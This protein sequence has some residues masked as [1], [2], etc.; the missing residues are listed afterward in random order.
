MRKPNLPRKRPRRSLKQIL[1]SPRIA[2]SRFSRSAAFTPK[3]TSNESGAFCRPRGSL[4]HFLSI[5]TNLYRRE[6]GGSKLEYDSEN[7]IFRFKWWGK[8]GHTYFIQH[9]E[10]LVTWNWLPL[11]EPG[12]NSIKEWAFTSTGNKFFVRLRYTDLVTADAADGDFDGDGVPY[13]AEVNQG[14]DPFVKLDSDNDGMPDDWEKFFLS[15]LTFTATQDSDG[16][17]SSNLQEYQGATAPND[18]ASK[19]DEPSIRYALLDLSQVGMDDVMPKAINNQ[20]VLCGNKNN[21]VNTSPVRWQNGQLTQLSSF[22][23][24]ARDIND[25]GTVI[26]WED[27]AGAERRLMCWPGGAL[28]IPS[29]WA[30]AYGVRANPYEL[31]SINIS[32]EITGSLLVAPLDAEGNPINTSTVSS[33]ATYWKDDLVQPMGYP[34]QEDL[35]S[36][37]GA[38]LEIW[39]IALKVNDSGQKLVHN[40]QTQFADASYTNGVVH[41]DEWSLDGTKLDYKGRNGAS[42][43]NDRGEVLG[44]RGSGWFLRKA[45]GTVDALRGGEA[46]ALNDAQRRIVDT[47]GNFLRMEPS[48]QAVGKMGGAGAIWEK[49]QKTNKF[50]QVWDLN[51]RLSPA[52]QDKWN[53]TEAI[54]INDAGV[55][56][57]Q[58]RNSQSSAD[59]PVLLLPV[60]MITI[61]SFIPHNYV[62]NPIPFSGSIF[63]GDNRNSGSPARATWNAKGSHRTHTEFNIVA[64]QIADS[65]GLLDN[66]YANDSDGVKNDEYFVNIGTTREYDKATSLNSSGNISAAAKADTSLNDGNLKIAETT[67]PKSDV[68]IE[69]TEFLSSKKIAVTCRCEAPNPLVSLSFFGPISYTFVITIDK[70]NPVAPKYSLTGKCK[71]FPAYE[72]YIG[73]S[74]IYQYD[75]LVDGRTPSW[76]LLPPISIPDQIDKP[77]P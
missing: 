44:Q 26:G 48:T 50:Y 75:P 55:I 43:L 20:G 18:S 71:S 3:R 63:E 65:N 67:A 42:D 40:D 77:L 35:G 62:D 56:V 11:V 1:L 6:C 38:R 2:S 25:L 5:P 14:T 58:A 74:R 69:K 54:D 22:Q 60:E 52:T 9:S 57:A 7:S 72:V 41:K 12:D 10:N 59:S 46:A 68:W 51:Q 19:P 21:G 39:D 36:S 13:L 32:G 24:E 73:N 8:A 61:N 15:T 34:S 45:S 4:S 49:D 31:Y 64:W 28:V 23:G 70:T 33:V 53:V 47:A 16:D 76:L 29:F 30:E 37:Y 66:A 27:E 17:G